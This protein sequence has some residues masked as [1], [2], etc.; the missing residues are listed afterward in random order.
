[1]PV[2]KTGLD[3]KRAA[4]AKA[5]MPAVLKDFHLR[6]LPEKRYAEL[7]DMV[8][9]GTFDP[10]FSYEAFPLLSPVT[11]ILGQADWREGLKALFSAAPEKLNEAK[12]H[13][14]RSYS[15]GNKRSFSLLEYEEGNTYWDSPILLVKYFSEEKKNLFEIAA[16]FPSLFYQRKVNP[17][18]EICPYLFDVATQ[19]KLTVQRLEMIKDV[20]GSVDFL[21]LTDSKG[22]TLFYKFLQEAQ[23]RDVNALDAATWM[24]MH[25][26]ELVNIPDHLG[27]TILD[28]LIVSSGGDY[29][30]PMGRLLVA[31]GAR[32]NRQVAPKF[33]LAAEIERIAEAAPLKKTKMLLPKSSGKEP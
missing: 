16:L 23:V 2:R 6:I 13:R 33:N 28:R 15:S 22:R 12:I 19:E 3:L 10:L 7:A 27:W 24:L 32:L 8:R 31:S 5:D 14:F 17:D 25:K 1:M 21:N 26:P 20:A 11:A 18:G 4:L 29:D 9:A 30:T